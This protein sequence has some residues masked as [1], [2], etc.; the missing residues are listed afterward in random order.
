MTIAIIIV[1]MGLLVGIF[2]HC[3]IAHHPDDGPA[4][5]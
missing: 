4:K 5:F 2:L 3:L 1:G